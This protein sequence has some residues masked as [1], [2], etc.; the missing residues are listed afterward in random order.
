[1][2]ADISFPVGR[3]HRHLKLGRYAKR[4]GALAPVYLAAVMEF[5]TQE[6]L[7]LA[8]VQAV[9]V[10]KKKRINPRALQLAV[11]SDAELNEWMSGVTMANGGVAPYKDPKKLLEQANQ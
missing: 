8:V 2:R 6:F 7:D 10:V 9:D 4:I 5:M 1:M 3:V 11:L